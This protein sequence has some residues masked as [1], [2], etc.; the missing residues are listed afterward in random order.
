[1]ST[2][3]MDI[4]TPEHRFFEGEVQALTVDC[5]DGELTIL[6]NHQPMVAALKIGEIRIQEEDGSWREAFI[7]EGFVEVN[8]YHENVTV[9]VQACEWPEDIDV[10]R[11]KAALERAQRRMREKQSRID[12]RRSQISMARAMARLRATRQHTYDTD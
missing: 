4:L 9:Y 3:H 12:Y 6:K 5:L 2:F 1:M 11:A 8:L 10:N 7:S